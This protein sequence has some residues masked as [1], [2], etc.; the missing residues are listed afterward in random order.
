MYRVGDKVRIHR[1]LDIDEYYGGIFFDDDMFS[2]RGQVAVIRRIR[3]SGT[4]ELDVDDGMDDWSD[5]MF[6]LVKSIDGINRMSTDEFED[7]YKDANI[8]Y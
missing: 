8:N 2:H 7:K 1:W 4:F 3:A 5:E 6:E